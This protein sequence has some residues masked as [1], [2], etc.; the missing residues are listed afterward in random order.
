LKDSDPVKFKDFRQKAKAINFGILGGQGA[1][2]LVAYAR[3]N[4]NVVLTLE[5]A[6]TWRGRLITEVYP[7]ICLYLA[8][9]SLKV[10]ADNLGCTKLELWAG[11]EPRGKRPLWFPIALQR[12][13]AGE[14]KRN[15]E[16]YNPRFCEQIWSGL[17]SCCQNELHRPMIVA[18]KAGKEM[19]ALL[20]E[21]V[22]TPSGR[23]RASCAYTE[24]RNSPFQGLASDGAKEAIFELVR[25]GYRVVGF[26]HDELILELPVDVDHTAEAKRIEQIV[27]EAMSSVIDNT[28]P[29]SA[30]YALST[31]WSKEAKC[32]FDKMGRLIPWKP[33]EDK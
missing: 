29:V 2:S 14:N 9:R 5:Q 26:V 13:L 30:D 22:V 17:A 24:A 3:E 18:R 31:V 6:E 10:L 7:E 16:R 33:K 28:V 1:V 12:I 32:V 27:C 23:I 11:L 8:D 19:A 20:R 4:Y 15:G 25:L 21:S